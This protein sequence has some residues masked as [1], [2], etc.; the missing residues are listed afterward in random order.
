LFS[1][2]I[3]KRLFQSLTEF[4]ESKGIDTADLTQR[5]TT[6]QNTGVYVGGGGTINAGS[7]AAGS[8]A[9]ATSVISRVANAARQ[10]VNEAVGRS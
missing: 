6:I 3:D 10:G 7:I 5:R 1:K 9:R 8:G 2:V 4:F